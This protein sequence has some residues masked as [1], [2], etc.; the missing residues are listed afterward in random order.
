M[1]NIHWVSLSFQF[2][3]VVLGFTELVFVDI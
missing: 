1:S 2:G 3:S